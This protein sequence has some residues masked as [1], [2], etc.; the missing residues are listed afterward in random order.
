MHRSGTSL[1]CR[2]LNLCGMEL[3]DPEDL[4]PRAPDNPDGFWENTRFVALNDAVLQASGEGWDW[5]SPQPCNPSGPAVESL[6][7]TAE[8]LVGEFSE[9]PF[10]GWKDPRNSLTLPFWLSVVPDAWVVLVV[11]NP[12][13]VA[14]SLERRNGLSQ[15]FALNLWLTYN[16]RLQESAEP[17]RLV[18]THFDSY[19]EAPE[20][21]LSR[22]VGRLGVEVTP[23]QVKEAC[24]HVSPDSRHARVDSASSLWEVSP[25]AFSLYRWLC[26][27]AARPAPDPDAARLA[28]PDRPDGEHEAV[29]EDPW[30]GHAP[31]R[32]Q[33]NHQDAR[34]LVRKGRRLSTALLVDVLQT[35]NSSLARRLA[36]AEAET[37]AL[38]E[39]TAAVEAAL[40]RIHSSRF[41]RVA[42]IYWSLRRR[43]A[44]RSPR[45]T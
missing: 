33:G 9:R 29:R 30:T 35:R 8:R 27:A 31:G 45:P 5:V 4:M 15:V 12:L 34:S 24:A 32:P 21:E 3:G 11:R 41:W 14:R 36:E 37:R 16:E 39:R 20:A 6:I 13:E 28:D 2:L 7:P 1:V 18:V 19:F 17:S 23:E 38:E 22:L 40:E 10:W 43:L 26:H 25:H 42:S 44:R